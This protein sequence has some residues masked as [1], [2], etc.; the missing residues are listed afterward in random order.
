MIA[1]SP[2]DVKFEEEEKKMLSYLFFK[3]MKKPILVAFLAL[4][5]A[6]CSLFRAKI[7][8]YPTGIV[9]PLEIA[10][11]IEYQ[12]E[13]IN[14][15]QTEESRIYVATRSGFLY[16][17]DGIKKQK[18][19][20]LR[21][22]RNLDISP[23][24]GQDSLY[25]FDN[26]S[27]LFCVDKNGSLLWQKSIGARITSDVV[28]KGDRIF[29]GTQDGRLITF[30]SSQGEKIWEYQAGTAIQSNLVVTSGS[31]AFGGEDGHLYLLDLGGK[32]IKKFD[33]GGITGHTLAAD[34]PYLYLGTETKEIFCFDLVKNKQKWKIKAGGRLLIP[35][36]FDEKRGFFSCL[37]NVLYCLNKKNG[38]IEWWSAVPSRS[39]YPLVII[40][41]RIVVTSLSSVLMSFN[42]HTGETIGT[43]EAEREIRSNPLWIQPYLLINLYDPRYDKGTLLIV[44]KKVAVTLK[45]SLTSPQK[46]NTQILFTATPSGFHLPEYKFSI[47]RL[48]KVYINPTFFIFFKEEGT[49]EIVQEKSEKNTWEW[50]PE[51]EGLYGIGVKVTDEKEETQTAVPFLIQ[52]EEPQV[53]LAFSKTS[54]QPVG[55]DIQFTATVKGFE[56]PS[57]EFILHRV[58][59]MRFHATSFIFLSRQKSV[60]QEKSNSNL[61]T[62]SPDKT[63]L[64]AVEVVVEDKAEKKTALSLFRIKKKAESGEEKK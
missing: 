27:T 6:S 17:F 37:N 10:S 23:C 34:G 11:E 26:K 31:L 47:S 19:W 50:F 14:P 58:F 13:I 48:Q 28:N 64:F 39:V 12:G 5:L 45:A 52:K 22:S 53:T 62:W 57:L 43:F 49:E 63:G 35:P 24:L 1:T 16:C 54:P 60:V 15:M 7:P 51:K 36:V 8:P 46:I 33:I 30:R 2:S 55:E 38:T 18:I 61:W 32:L 40:E 29:L 20:E 41:K 4:I 42:T 3:R 9:F 25:V 56:E 21:V 44:Q 59:I